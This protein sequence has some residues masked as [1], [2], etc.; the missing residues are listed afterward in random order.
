[1]SSD[2]S[3]YDGSKIGRSNRYPLYEGEQFAKWIDNIPK[4]ADEVLNQN[5]QI[6]KIAKKIY[7]QENAF[8]IGRS[9]LYPV[10]LEGALKLKE[11][12]YIHAE[13]YHASELKHGP[14]ALLEKNTPVIA[15]LNDIPG[16]D[17]THGNAEECKA[18]GASVI[19]VVT[20]GDEQTADEFVDKIIVPKC[21]PMIATIPTTITLQLLSYHIAVLRGC[22]VDQPRNLA[23]SVTV[24]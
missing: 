10:A 18:R 19:A 6:K 8:F 20:D 2:D 9:F 7:K 15:L 12:S 22:D 14:I 23:K 5:E 11:I 3:S 17:K 4:L 13:G 24:E 16:K 21:P 1:M